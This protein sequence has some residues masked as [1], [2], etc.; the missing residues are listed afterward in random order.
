[1]TSIGSIIDHG[2]FGRGSVVRV[3]GDS[4]VV[5]FDTGETR[6]ISANYASAS[7]AT[8]PTAPP[9]SSSDD[10]VPELGKRWVGGT[11][12]LL[13]GNTETQPKE[14]P[15]EY[16]FKKIIGVREKLRVMEQKVNN[17]PSLSLEEKLELEDYITRCYGSLT[18]FNALFAKK[19]SYFKGQGGG[20]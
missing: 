18:T 11:V 13:P 6:T 2:V 10:S 15:I 3:E 9:V 17:H 1:M 12:K 16:F 7:V 19:E 4:L 14:F 20:E 8:R 5:A